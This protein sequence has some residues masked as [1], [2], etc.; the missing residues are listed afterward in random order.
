MASASGRGSRAAPG[1]R[2]RRLPT[3]SGMPRVGRD[4]GQCCE[5]ASIRT[6]GRPSRSPSPAMRLASTNRSAC[7]IGGQHDSCGRAP[8]QST[9][10]GHAEPLGLRARSRCDSGAAADMLEAPVQTARQ[11][12]QRRRAGSSKPFFSTARPT[13]AGSDRPRRVAAVG[14]RAAERRREALQVEAVI[15]QR[16]RRLSRR[17]RRQVLD[18]GAR[19]GRRPSAPPQLLALLPVGRRPDVLGVRRERSTAGRGAARHSARPRPACAG[20]ARAASPTSRRQLGREHQGL[21]EAAA[22]GCGVGSRADR[23]AKAPR[24]AREAGQP[25][26]LAPGRAG[27]AAARRAG[28]PADRGPAPRSAGAARARRGRS[29]GAARRSAAQ[30][31]PL[32]PQRSPAR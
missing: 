29:D 20:N 25:P 24:A 27:P 14:P 1:G 28:I 21:A 2:V 7:A 15:D 9:R 18:A 26:R 3:S 19:A 6:L 22:R 32:Q 23:A 8:S 4:D 16:R 5:S 10:A 12:R 31:A 13:A 17:E 30:A 11:Q